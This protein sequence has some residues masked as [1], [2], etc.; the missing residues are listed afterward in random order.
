[1]WNV[2]FLQ[3]HSVPNIL[4]TV[5]TNIFVNRTGPL[6]FRGKK[7][8]ISWDL[9]RQIRRENGRFCG[10][11]LGKFS[12]KSKHESKKERF[13]RNIWFSLDSSANDL[14]QLSSRQCGRLSAY[15][16]TFP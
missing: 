3:T 8:E 14:L 5:M 1:M 2:E 11:F 4:I 9:K 6:K 16:K 10:N 7:K 13:L 15:L 12:L